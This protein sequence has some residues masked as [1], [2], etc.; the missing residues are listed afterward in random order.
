MRAK[1]VRNPARYEWS[2]AAFRLGDERMD[3]LVTDRTLL[4][5]IDD[6]LFLATGRPLGE[7]EF[8]RDLERRTGRRLVPRKGGWPKGRKRGKRGN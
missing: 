8:V 3:P 5:I 7:T 4:G 6:G 1:L 2:S